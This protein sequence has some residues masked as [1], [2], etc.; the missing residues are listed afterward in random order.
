MGHPVLRDRLRDHRHLLLGQPVEA[1]L[2]DQR[3]DRED[4]PRHVRTTGRRV[5]VGRV[6]QRL[7]HQGGRLVTRQIAAVELLERTPGED[8]AGPGGGE[9]PLL[10]AAAGDVVAEDP[11]TAQVQVVAREERDDGQ[12]L[13]RHAQVAP[14]H[15]GEAVGLALQREHGALDL[16]VVLQLQLEEPD[17]LH[18]EPGGAGDAD[19]AVL[20]GREDLLDVPLGDHIA[21]GGPPVTG[22]HHPA[23]E[24]R[25]DD[26]GPVRRVDG[27]PRREHTASGEQFRRMV[28]QEL[29]E[30]RGSGGEEGSR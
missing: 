9:S 13:H 23:G 30:R 20:V 5:V 3:D 15:G 11:A 14:D 26:G 22:D 6:V 7:D 19:R 29:D 2:G 21:H 1:V 10:G 28:R 4:L 17:H 16:L 25:R 12:A 24:D 27:Q 18:R 8:R